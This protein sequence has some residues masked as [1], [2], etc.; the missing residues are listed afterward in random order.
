VIETITKEQTQLELPDLP[1]LAD[2]GI[3]VDLHTARIILAVSSRMIVA[4]TATDRTALERAMR[5]VGH[6]V[7][8]TLADEDGSVL[9]APMPPPAG[10]IT[11]N[12]KSAGRRLGVPTST[13][14]RAWNDGPV[15]ATSCLPLAVVL[16]YLP[17]KAWAYLGAFIA[18]GPHEARLRISVAASERGKSMTAKALDAQFSPAQTLL[19]HLVDGLRAL[20]AANERRSRA[21]KALLPIPPALAAW[22]FVPKKLSMQ[23]IRAKAQGGRKLPTSAVPEQLVKGR[24]RELARRAEWGRWA[25]ADWP[26]NRKWQALRDLAVFA[27]LA[28]LAPRVDHFAHLDARDVV[29]RCTFRDGT[30]G[31]ALLFRGGDHGLKNRGDSYEYAVRLPAVLADILVAWLACNGNSPTEAAR[32]GETPRRHDTR[33]PLFPARMKR[34][35]QSSQTAHRSLGDYIAGR[36][37]SAGSA[38]SPPLLVDPAGSGRG[39]QAHRF[40]S[41]LTQ[42]IDRLMKSWRDEHPTHPLAGYAEEAAAECI[43]D[44][45]R[46]DLGYRDFRDANGPTARFEQLVALGVEAWWEELWADGPYQQRGLDP[47]A[48]LDAHQQ[49]LLLRAEFMMVDGEAADLKDQARKLAEDALARPDADEMVHALLKSVALRDERDARLERRE[50]LRARLSAAEAELKAAQQTKVLL[51]EHLSEQDH[52]EQ[53][54]AAL[55]LVADEPRPEPVMQSTRLLAEELT[56][57]DVAELFGVTQQQV[58]RWRRGKSSPPVDPAAWIQYNAKDFR[59]PAGALDDQARR[60]VPS[61]DPEKAVADILA[62]RASQGF[63]ARQK[64]SQREQPAFSGV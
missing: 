13:F 10:P 33:V 41:T 15:Y 62:R 6:A 44:H 14:N 53:L 7:S 12:G 27:V 54:A 35:P 50:Q 9:P 21:G 37:P 1:T 31:P 60:R 49:V 19:V 57:S 43:L 36:S 38:H 28:T 45:T 56:T 39:F 18:C 52:A 8:L 48:I 23:E 24:L 63:G 4:G 16:A 46:Q 64:S 20:E 29:L 32:A 42:G 34:R 51:P 59:L 22:T 11:P 58:G 2:H 26:L 40:R 3:E 55:A 30:I 5:V 25:A 47:D 61:A 17:A